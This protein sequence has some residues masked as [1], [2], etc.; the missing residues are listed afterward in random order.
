MSSGGGSSSDPLPAADDHDPPVSTCAEGVSLS[1]AQDRTDTL[2]AS[3]GGG[4]GMGGAV[5][6]AAAVAAAGG[7]SVGSGSGSGNVACAPQLSAPA[8]TDNPSGIRPVLQ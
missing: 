7:V 2:A 4:D 8:L 3:S 1:A 5:A 6:T